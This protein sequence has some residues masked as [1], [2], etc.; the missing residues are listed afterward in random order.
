MHVARRRFTD[1][2]FAV[3]MLALAPGFEPQM[4]TTRV[5]S[6]FPAGRGRIGP[7]MR[8]VCLGL[9]LAAGLWIMWTSHSELHNTQLMNAERTGTIVVREPGAS[10]CRVVAFDNG[11]GRF[12]DQR[13]ESCARPQK[14]DRASTVLESFRNR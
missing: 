14:A 11:T 5:P 1:L 2:K 6:A 10:T 9:L 4:I 13:S 12:G 8:R 3:G 7:I